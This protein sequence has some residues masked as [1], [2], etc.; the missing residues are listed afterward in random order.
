[1]TARLHAERLK[2][3]SQPAVA[4]VENLALH[5]AQ[6]VANAGIDDD[7]VFAARD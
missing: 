3:A 1:V 6:P 5:R 4:V 7:R 2:P